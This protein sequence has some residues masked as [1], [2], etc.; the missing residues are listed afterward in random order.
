MASLFSCASSRPIHTH[1]HLDLT[2]SPHPRCVHQGSAEEDGRVKS[3]DRVASIDGVSTAGISLP[4][5]KRMVVG[6]AGTWVNFVFMR[7]EKGP[8]GQTREVMVPVELERKVKANIETNHDRIFTLEREKLVLIERNRYLQSQVTVYQDE[9]NKSASA[10][11]KSS[12]STE[13]ITILQKQLKDMEARASASAASA[14]SAGEE[15]S[16]LNRKLRE[17]AALMAKETARANELAEKLIRSGAFTEQALRESNERNETQSRAQQQTQRENTELRAKLTAAVAEVARV[18][19]LCAESHASAEDAI[20]ERELIDRDLEAARVEIKT[21]RAESNANAK[22]ISEL[23][24]EIS[25]LT[26]KLQ[27]RGGHTSPTRDTEVQSL[28]QLCTIHEAKIASLTNQLEQLQTSQSARLSSSA[29]F[30]AGNH[31]VVLSM[32][33]HIDQLSAE[34]KQSEQTIVSL[35]QELHAS[36]TENAQRAGH[37][38]QVKTLT[39]L[40]KALRQQLADAK[41]Q[42]DQLSTAN[43]NLQEQLQRLQANDRTSQSQSSLNE[44]SLQ[45]ALRVS[46]EYREKTD[47]E[48]KAFQVSSEQTIFGLKRDLQRVQK[49]L[50]EQ[51]AKAAEL[52]QQASA[53]TQSRSLSTH[54]SSHTATSTH[55]KS[56][57]VNVTNVT[58]VVQLTNGE[59]DTTVLQRMLQE[60]QGRIIEL[61]TM[62]SRLR[63]EHHQQ[64]KAL[65][66]KLQAAEDLSVKF[67]RDHASSETLLMDAK[68]ELTGL[69]PRYESALA[70][71]G[72]VEPQLDKL[73]TEHSTVTSRLSVSETRCSELSTV[74]DG[75]R[76][77]LTV[78]EQVG[79]FLKYFLCDASD[80]SQR[81]LSYDG[82]S[83]VMSPGRCAVAFLMKVRL[84]SCSSANFSL[85]CQTHSLR[86]MD[87]AAI[88]NHSRR[89]FTS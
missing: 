2:L 8:N 3:G 9:A 7:G 42:I 19:Q 35:Q 22:T 6:P 81:A 24:N 78:A 79:P 21:I 62:I 72:S 47:A 28:K 29:S 44:D 18:N 27:D 68:Q 51:A 46:N 12:A 36:Q 87:F 4:E 82:V 67:R 58:R 60:A 75:L 65:S 52:Q 33:S 13:E 55:L 26:A 1:P 40:S 73:R 14:A 66:M 50:V 31:P 5:V 84:L 38:K 10:L 80:V 54:T 34:K 69:R 85:S 63:E 39:D 64:Y 77:R 41:D 74:S 32:Q 70:K 45:Q 49:E 17:A 15:V 59:T 88:A 76:A 43:R 83:F 86:P 48:F 23:L 30:D 61:E 11:R 57:Q 89:K 71:L 37:E 56:E 16:L 20:R 53:S 25:G